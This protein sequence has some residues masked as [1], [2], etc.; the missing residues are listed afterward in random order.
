MG[1]ELQENAF[2]L[3]LTGLKREQI[4][5]LDMEGYI[6]RTS[7][8]LVSL[9]GYPERDLAGTLFLD[10]LV[11]ES[12]NQLIRIHESRMAAESDG[13]RTGLIRADLEMKRKDGKS[14]ATEFAFSPERDHAGAVTG[15]F[16]FCRE[17]PR[18]GAA[19]FYTAG[20]DLFGPF[21]A[22]FP[23]LAYIKDSEGRYLF[24]NEGFRT[25]L[26]LDPVLM[27]G[28]LPGDF[29]PA[30]IAR[31]MTDV[32][33]QVMAAGLPVVQE[34][35][36]A[37]RVWLVRKFRIPRNGGTALLGGL[38]HDITDRTRAVR[39]LELSQDRL[40]R[41]ELTA[42]FGHWEFR[43]DDRSAFASDGAREIYGLSD[44]EI[45][46]D[47]VQTI[48]LPEYRPLLNQALTDLING[49]HP[50][51]VEFRIRRPLDGSVAHIHSIATYDPEKRIIS[52]VIQDISA[53]KSAE[54]AFNRKSEEMERYFETAQDLFCITD[55]EGRFQMLNPQ[56]K[57][58]L[59][60]QPEEMIGRSFMDF[61]HPD[62]R[63]ATL[64]ADDS[65]RAGNP[66][67]D[68]VNRY[69][70]ADGHWRWIEWRSTCSEEGRLFAAARDITERKEREEALK[71][72][73]N[74]AEESDR[75]KTAF[76][77]NISHEIR[78]PMN[79]IV[80]FAELLA[81]PDL[82]EGERDEFITII[83]DSSRQ[84]LR[85]VNDMLD[86]SRIEAGEM[87]S[88]PE[89]LGVG[90]LFDELAL[91]YRPLCEKKG[92]VLTVETD[93]GGYLWADPVKLRQILDNLLVNA[94]KFTES[95]SVA[96]GFRKENGAALLS[97]EDTGPGVP[98]DD[99]ERIFERF[100]RIEQN[101]VT[102]SG[103]TGLGLPI[104]R[105]LA[106]L[107]KGDLVCRSAESGGSRFCLTLP[108]GEK[109][110]RALSPAWASTG[111]E[112]HAGKGTLMV[113]E[114]EEMNWQYTLA[115]LKGSGFHVIR[116]ATGLEALSLLETEDPAVI[117]LD[118]KLPDIS[119]LDV[120]R[121]LR[122]QGRDLP[123]VALTAFAYEADR[124]RALNAGCNDYLIKPVRR[125]L[126]LE[127]VE[128]AMT[129]KIRG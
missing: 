7:P 32:D 55:S 91:V 48:P 64:S 47:L 33:R 124:T 122:E 82:S 40:L 103:G 26:G 77:A 51:D 30:D 104:A 76:L 115:A 8:A 86:I 113:V 57:K 127:T 84:L 111:E 80:G 16:A 75:L 95:G 1:S 85:I 61:V 62:D 94:L 6:V 15:F 13:I 106:R 12:R 123:V 100:H 52:G 5:K 23:G 53:R 24:V 35:T 59:G 119:G 126:L 50:Y 81:D 74:K 29:F 11:E 69:I 2:F 9:T 68:F 101:G 102:V 93:P 92:L 97:V 128:A 56:W 98:P 60:Y 18:A 88:K 38:S 109:P 3:E 125:D 105:A 39:D 96:L 83:N 118:I 4:W 44:R 79:G 43:L 58:T 107:M 110:S 78:T 54:E 66:I 14:A 71:N 63:Q 65:L 42:G 120:V 116:A 19:C 37:G 114:D 22:H 108:L 129:R 121:H 46:I 41:A 34:A 112:N 73:M 10:L 28:R 36:Y 99:R 25:L 21:M 27:I 90:D 117:L 67:T 17:I 20:E 70:T 89:N 87:V 72:A 45:T 49:V 31:E